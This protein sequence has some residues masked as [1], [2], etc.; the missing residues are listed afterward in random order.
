MATTRS[1]EPSLSVAAA[2][3]MKGVV[4]R[5]THPVP[6]H[7]L[8]QLQAQVRDYVA[9]LGLTVVIDEAEG[10]A[11]LRSQPGDDETQPAVPRLIPR[12]A[13]SFHVSL[14][15]ALLR[16]K[17]AEFDASNADTRL[18][19]TR[20]QIVDLCAVFL[21]TSTSEARLIDQIDGHLNKIVELGFLRRIDDTEAT[22]EVRRII[23]AFVDAQWLADFDARLAE[24]AAEL[25]A[26][27]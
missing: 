9:V 10:Y 23:K 11:F 18:V 7:H 26:T 6:W 8:T 22:Y 13:L 24:Y 14:L 25:E 3:L 27:R 4:Y 12:R 19:L 21:P 1:D 2:H 16:K 20:Q 15:L 17:L 5:D